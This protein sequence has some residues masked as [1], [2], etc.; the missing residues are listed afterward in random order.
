MNAL[1][2]R[3]LARRADSSNSLTPPSKPE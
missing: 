3:A 2:V 1:T